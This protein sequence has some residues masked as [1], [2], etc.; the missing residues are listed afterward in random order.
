[1]RLAACLRN[2]MRLQVRHGFYVVYL[3][4]SVL[5]VVV[6]RLLP[7]DWRTLVAPLVIFTDPAI[8]GLFLIGAFLTYERDDGTLDTL[9]V[10][11]VKVSDYLLAKAG[12]LTVMALG[13]SALIA[14]ASMGGAV[15]WTLLVPTVILTSMLFVFAGAALASRITVL[16][17]FLLL[18]GT[19]Q[20][21]TLLPA[22]GLF[23]IVV[24][25]WWWAVPTHGALLLLRAAFGHAT[26]PIHLALALVTLAGWT[27]LAGWWAHRWLVR[28]VV[29]KSGGRA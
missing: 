13:S 3:A 14:G 8:L 17:R 11:P 12:S 20:M 6:L 26:P 16:T 15:R 1:M 23:E 9:F 2:D 10:S 29:N 22:L 24:T 27:A 18:A 21:L 28:F 7:L 19:S 5:Y 4:V 25:P